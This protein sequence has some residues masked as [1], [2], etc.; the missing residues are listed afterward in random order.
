MD[1]SRP[2]LDGNAFAGLLREIFTEDLT[3]ARGACAGCG[4]V[5]RIG[6]QHLYEYPDGPGAVLR[7]R[8]CESVLMV[9]VSRERRYRIG[10]QGLVWI[11][12]AVT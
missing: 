8:S 4:A 7:C 11:D 5:A 2:R 12:M 3:A 1:E 9:I 6:D 10:A